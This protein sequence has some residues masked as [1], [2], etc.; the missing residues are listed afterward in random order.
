MKL[1]YM[2]DL[3]LN[4]DEVP[5]LTLFRQLY[6][7]GIKYAIDNPKAVKMVAYLYTSKDLIYKE[8]MGDGLIKAREFYKGYIESDIKLG[9]INPEI[10]A[11]V[12]SELMVNLINNIS[13]DELNKDNEEINF[14]KML[15]KFDKLIFILEK[16]ILNGE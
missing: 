1:G 3:L 11:D 5:F 16:G 10:D 13:L 7:I 8:V 9:R 14:N 6:K 15:D 4:P 12:F 2:G